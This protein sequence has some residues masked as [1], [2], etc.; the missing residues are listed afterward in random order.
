M[1]L[2]GAVLQPLYLGRALRADGARSPSCS[3]RCAGW[4]R[5]RR[6]RATTSGGPNFAYELCARADRRGRA[7]PGSTCRLGKWRS[8]AP[9]RC[10]RRRLKRFAAAFAGCGFR[11]RAFYPVLRPGGGDAVRSRLRPAG[12]GVG[13]AGGGGGRRRA[14][15]R[16][17]PGGWGRGADGGAGGL[18]R[19][20][21]RAA[22]GGRRS[23]DRRA[24]VRRGGWGRS[25]WRGRASRPATGAGRRR[26]LRPSER[27]WPAMARARIV[28][29]HR[30]P[31]LRARRRAVRHGAAQGPD[32][33][34]RPQPL[35]AG[36]GADRRGQPSGA[37]AG[38]R[39]RPSRSTTAGPSAW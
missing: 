7:A 27:G 3:G 15:A 13:A 26:R 19:G 32:D 9:S 37:A 25:G 28:P 24:A 12:G 35:S 36:P 20:L 38:R 39:A 16:R 30:R 10:G 1:G 33:P 21:G 14:G 2:I 6:Y 11:R 5:S 22:A 23:R 4:R 34:A 18:R 17:G 29:A 31:R 8:T